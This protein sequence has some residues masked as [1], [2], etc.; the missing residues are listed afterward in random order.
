MLMF[1][2]HSNNIQKH[3]YIAS[4][5]FQF[6][7]NCTELM[8]AGFLTMSEWT[9]RI[10][11]QN[12][13]ITIC[14]IISRNWLFSQTHPVVSE[15]GRSIKRQKI[16]RLTDNL[17]C[18][19]IDFFYLLGNAEISTFT[20]SYQVKFIS[21]RTTKSPL[22]IIKLHLSQSRIASLHKWQWL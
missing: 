9:I 6:P 5:W 16:C 10:L 20:Y 17:I 18:C 11:H 14:T 13:K 7:R 19:F 12:A 21:W 15:T 4:V 2:L 3:W 8:V 22:S 1:D